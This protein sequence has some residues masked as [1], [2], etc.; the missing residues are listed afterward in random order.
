[1]KLKYSKS[2]IS[3]SELKEIKNI[4]DPEPS[5][6]DLRKSIDIKLRK[7][8]QEKIAKWKNTIQNENNLRL[9]REKNEF[10]K[11]ERLRQKIDEEERKYQNMRYNLSLQK[12]RDYLFNSK[13]LV[14]SFNSSMLYS[15]TLKE[16][17][18]QI[19]LNKSI[20]MRKEKDEQDWIKKE[21]EQ[22]LAYDMKELE[23]KKLR[24]N[25]SE[26]EMNIIRNQFNEVKFKRLQEM[27]DNYIEG[28]IIKREARNALLEEQKKKEAIKLAR[29]K[30][31]EEFVKRNE[32]LKKYLEKK[33]Q[34][35]LEDDK[36]IEMHAKYKEDLE[37]LKKRKEKEKFEEKQKR[38]QKLI[39]VQFEN[40]KRIKEEQ[41][42]KEN[43]D[44]E[45]KM[46]KD[47]NEEKM[48]IEKRNKILK[49]M[50]EQ[51]LEN[52]KRKE[53]N[54]IKE[55]IEEM[56]E[57]EEIRKKINEEREKEKNEYLMKRKKVKDLHECYKKQVED[58]KK[59]A[60]NDFVFERQA[61]LYNKEMMNKEEDEFLQYAQEN[62]KKYRD[63][64]KN[65][66]PMLLELKKYKKNNNL[67]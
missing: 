54:K 30:Q 20:K 7:I 1:M 58:K 24:R 63:Q 53:E 16:R 3:L 59:M 17:D 4:I 38:Q 10:I 47:E 26:A 56:K 42:K 44:V 50:E 37:N 29:I 52:I 14:K 60:F 46:R 65:I 62:I 41:E 48:K 61:G 21:K 22:M 34:K 19:E 31:N 9:E 33:K 49:E 39:D 43:K 25:K 28:E 66:V 8:S 32:E 40:L 27:Q 35:E 51:R 5:K 18:K 11:K 23:K 13:D 36:L 64:G 57:I 2:V 67:Q 15:D 12:A 55:K 6:E 45:I